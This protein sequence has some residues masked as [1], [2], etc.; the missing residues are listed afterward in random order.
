G[1]GIDLRDRYNLILPVEIDETAVVEPEEEPVEEPEEEP[2]P[3]EEAEEVVEA[4]APTP[5]PAPAPQPPPPAPA[6]PPT[7]AQ[8]T[9][10]EIIARIGSLEVLNP[11]SLSP[12]VMVPISTTGEY[13]FVFIS[14][15][16]G[17]GAAVNIAGGGSSASVVR[18]PG[19]NQNRTGSITLRAT[20]PDGSTATKTYSVSIPNGYSAPYGVVTVFE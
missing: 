2:E 4:P 9:A 15:S 6:P 19:Q 11:A 14:A 17:E 5:A 7:P 12:T 13:T 16:A 18:N 3:E 8:P 1:P 10:S 20:G